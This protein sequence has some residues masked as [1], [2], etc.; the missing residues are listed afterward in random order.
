METIPVDKL[1]A[2]YFIRLLKK[3]AEKAGDPSAA[4]Y[5][6]L[7]N[8]EFYKIKTLAPDEFWKD[9]SD[10]SAYEYFKVKLKY[11][12]DSEK[13]KLRKEYGRWSVFKKALAE[14]SE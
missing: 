6:M 3:A 7:A 8:G 5:Y 1:K 14:M 4:F 2:K 11:G 9:E 10:K 12:S 13:S